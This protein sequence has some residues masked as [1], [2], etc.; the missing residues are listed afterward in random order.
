MGQLFD[1]D[2]KGVFK[3]SL[4]KSTYINFSCLDV[5]ISYRYYINIWNGIHHFL[6]QVLLQGAIFARNTIHDLHVLHP[7]IYFYYLDTR[8]YS[9]L[10][11]DQKDEAK[12][13]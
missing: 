2:L 6:A 5:V 4:K 8:G 12:G 11:E 10:R 13:W 3:E 7:T 1:G 9:R